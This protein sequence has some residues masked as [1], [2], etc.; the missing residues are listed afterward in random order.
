MKCILCVIVFAMIIA[1]A[2]KTFSQS[3]KAGAIA[4][5]N[6]EKPKVEASY[7]N[8]TKK[9]SF[10]LSD[11]GDNANLQ[12]LRV[13]D[14]TFS[15][16][17]VSDTIVSLYIFY[18]PLKYEVK[19]NGGNIVSGRFKIK[20]KSKYDEYFIVPS[21]G[22]TGVS[23]CVA[24]EDLSLYFGKKTSTGYRCSKPSYKYQ[25]VM[26]SRRYNNWDSISFSENEIE[27]GCMFGRAYAKMNN[28]NMGILGYGYEFIPYVKY[29]TRNK[30]M[31]FG[32]NANIYGNWFLCVLENKLSSEFINGTINYSNKTS[33][34]GLI[35]VTDTSIGYE[36]GSFY[37]TKFNYFRVDCA[38]TLPFNNGYRPKHKQFESFFN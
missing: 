3:F 22:Y 1:I 16:D 34:G 25:G 7:D 20:E 10:T 36:F 35:G 23:S 29:S 14:M 33:I 8:E 19:D 26:L 37:G 15:L 30:E 12:T 38:I 27:A 6:D 28:E 24:H 17:G 13:D 2:N 32:A 21:W 18:S 9:V 4:T 31:G 5:A 11:N